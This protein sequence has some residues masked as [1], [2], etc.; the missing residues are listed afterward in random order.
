M[1]TIHFI[2]ALTAEDL[3]TIK[4][5]YESAHKGV[6]ILDYTEDEDVRYFEILDNISRMVGSH[7]DKI[8]AV[9]GAGI[10]RSFVK[11]ADARTFAALVIMLS[12]RYPETSFGYLGVIY[13]TD[14][15]LKVPDLVESDEYLFNAMMV[16]EEVNPLYPVA[17]AIS[18]EQLPL[19]TADSLMDDVAELAEE[20]LW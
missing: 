20:E 19:L 7:S 9:F 17:V 2:D 12:E 8:I 4:L 5:V 6:E 11:D 10:Y 14:P 1:S 13:P 16:S 3:T 15:E 18:H